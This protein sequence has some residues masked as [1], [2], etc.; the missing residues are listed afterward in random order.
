MHLLFE[1]ETYP[2]AELESLGLQRFYQETG[3]TTA[4]VNYVGFYKDYAKDVSVFTLPKIFL[5]N[6]K[7]FG[8]YDPQLFVQKQAREI[9]SR[10][11]FESARNL[12]E[13]IYF[14]LR[15]YQRERTAQTL[16]DRERGYA[17]KS[18]IGSKQ[19]GSFEAMLALIAFNKT[20]PDL[21]VQERQ[22]VESK[23]PRR[24]NWKKTFARNVPVEVNGEA[25]YLDLM[26]YSKKGRKSD[27]LLVI[28]YSLLSEFRQYDPAITIDSSVEILPSNKLSRLRPKIILFLRGSGSLYFSDK[29]RQLHSLLQ[30][31]YFAERATYGSQRIEFLFT[32]DFEIV[33]E[34]MVDSLISDDELLTQYKHLKDGK[35]I[36]HLFGEKDA[37]GGNR[38]IYIGDSKYYKD[39]NRVTGQRYKQFTYARNIIQENIYIINSGGE[40]IYSRNYRDSI[41]EGYNVTPNFFLLG[42]VNQDYT[43]G[44]GPVV[45]PDSQA[46]EFSCHFPN[47]LFDRDTLHVLYFKVDFLRLL[48]FY[49]G[50]QKRLSVTSQSLRDSVRAVVQTE[51]TR[52][53]GSKYE[54]FLL[55][56]PPDFIKQNFK[57]FHGKLFSSPSVSPKYVLAL[58]KGQK[59]NTEILSLLSKSGI[60]FD[61]IDL[62]ISRV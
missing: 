17:I 46:P 27:P 24:I 2:K 34:K 51:L 25:L 49:T 55:N 61:R 53:L 23:N 52:Y 59:E 60:P 35:Q 26:G 41:S 38:I 1:E 47:R 8:K 62:N 29:F 56:L 7:V 31:Y 36:D 37:F 3:E 20:N 32:D 40:T 13:Q 28:F 48:R 14:C 42:V 58:E 39:P 11:E 57:A 44:P 9:V 43:E 22:I 33:F 18:N 30:S 6:G 4:K 5:V 54:L 10:S 45:E 21:F 12:A 50:R 16:L 15:Q 19:A